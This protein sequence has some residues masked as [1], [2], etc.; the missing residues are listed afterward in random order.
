MCDYNSVDFTL[1]QMN[2]LVLYLHW[3]N[4]TNQSLKSFRLDF[5]SR[6]HML[7]DSIWQNAKHNIGLLKMAQFSRLSPL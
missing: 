2:T 7:S 3:P 5:Q 6:T 4:N 1:P